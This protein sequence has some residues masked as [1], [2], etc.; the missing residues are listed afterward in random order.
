[1]YSSN[2]GNRSAS[3][4]IYSLS[5]PLTGSPFVFLLLNL[6]V[7]VHV[8]LD[9]SE[10]VYI[11]NQITSRSN[12]L[13]PV[14]CFLVLCLSIQSIKCKVKNFEIKR[15]RRNTCS[16]NIFPLEANRTFECIDRKRE[17]TFFDPFESRRTLSFS[18]VSLELFLSPSFILWQFLL[19]HIGHRIPSLCHQRPP[20]TSSAL[21]WK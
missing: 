20:L 21:G 8:S 3:C 6:C 19:I 18:R 2:S 5:L 7:C 17:R 14:S 12:Y 4:T 10:C 13:K 1:M 15:E 16:W 11:I 9:I